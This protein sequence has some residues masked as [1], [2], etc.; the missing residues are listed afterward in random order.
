VNTA[1]GKANG[2]LAGHV[3][4]LC[5]SYARLLGRALIEVPDS[6]E[7]RAEALFNADFAVLSSGLEADPLFNY[8]NRTALGLFELDWSQLIATPARESAATDN[9]AKREQL[10]QQVRA[11]GYIEDYAGVRISAGG[12]RF[13]IE[14]ATVWNVVDDDDRY[15]GQAAMF[16]RWRNLE[17][18][19]RIARLVNAIRVRSIVGPV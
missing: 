16:P 18:S 14:C 11:H 9:Q 6:G 1:P 2:F 8:A 19:T 10:M 5:S 4:R 15:H 13:M 17:F 3:D 12:H 7:T